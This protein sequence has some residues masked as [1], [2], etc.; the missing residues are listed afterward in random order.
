MADVG[1]HGVDPVV[2]R[3]FQHHWVH[4]FFQ[5]GLAYQPQNPALAHYV[6]E[7]GSV[8]ETPSS[9]RFTDEQIQLLL[10]CLFD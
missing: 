7:N 4:F 9:V 6:N 10:T 2:M 1:V 3:C 5:E 8:I